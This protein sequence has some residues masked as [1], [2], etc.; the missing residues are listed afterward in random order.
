MGGGEGGGKMG[1]EGEAGM[2]DEGFKGE[3]WDDVDVD[4]KGGGGG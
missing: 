2:R 4:K 3:G 1:E